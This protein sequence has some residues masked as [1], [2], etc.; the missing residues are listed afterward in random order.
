MPKPVRRLTALF[1]V[2]FVVAF[3]AWVWRQRSVEYASFQLRSVALALA[4]YMEQSEG[5]LPD[6]MASLERAGVIR[7]TSNGVFVVEAEPTGRF[8]RI[9][10]PLLEIDTEDVDI[11]WSATPVDHTR[12]LLRWR[13]FPSRYLD[14]LAAHLTMQLV[15][16][17]DREKTTP[18]ADR[19]AE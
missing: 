3:V 6:R 16:L 2:A 18:K 8:R 5:E 12:P 11:V 14:D 10:P 9:G 7:C 1:V 4:A 17:I 19:S 13:R 15:D